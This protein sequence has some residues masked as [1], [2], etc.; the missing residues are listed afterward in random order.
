VGAGALWG[1]VAL[2]CSGPTKVSRTSCWGSPKPSSAL[3]GTCAIEVRPPRCHSVGAEMPVRPRSPVRHS[4]PIVVIGASPAGAT[5]L[6]ITGVYFTGSSGSPT[7]TIVGSGFG[8]QG[9]LGTP[10]GA[11]GGQSGSEYPTT[12]FTST[13]ARQT[14]WRS[15]QVFEGDYT[16]II[17]RSYTNTQITFTLGSYYYAPL[18][19]YLTTGNSY[20][21][22]VLGT[23]YSGIVEYGNASISTDV[24]DASANSAWS[25]SEVTGASAYDTAAV[26][27]VDDIAPTA[28]SPTTC[29]ITAGARA[30]PRPDTITLTGGV[31]PQSTTTSALG[32]GSY[33]FDASYSGDDVYSG[34]TSSCEPFRVGQTSASVGTL[35]DDVA[36]N[37]AWGGSE[38]TGRTPTTPRR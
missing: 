20:E 34:V 30:R 5:T 14:T 11:G 23:T 18:E 4:H 9:S 17:I 32:A 16:G 26:A 7:I 8:T 21:V 1:P 6:S 2:A 33:S 31:V 10:V 36:T 25:G 22:G 35:V 29:L 37:G 19:Y 13:T 38:V 28:P 24:Y 3:R 15:T 27:G 12:T